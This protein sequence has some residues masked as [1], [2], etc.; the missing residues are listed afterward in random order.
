M[1]FQTSIS[2]PVVL[3]FFNRPELTAQVFAKIK[4]ARPP[5]LFLISDGPRSGTPVEVEKVAASRMVVA[6]IDWPCEVFRNYSDVNLGCRQRVI[7]GLDWVFSQVDRAIILEDDCLPNSDFFRF[8]DEL[9]ERY[10]QD[11]RVGSIAGT[12]PLEHFSNHAGESYSF[13][14]RPD[15]WGWATW[16]RVWKKYDGDI[17]DWPAQ[18]KTNLLVE[19]F[20]NRRA[21]RYWRLALSGVY[22][23]ILDTWDIQLTYH[24]LKT[25][26]VSVFPVK[27]LVANIGFGPDATHTLDAKNELA[28]LTTFRMD[29]PLIHPNSIEV[30][31][32]YDKERDSRYSPAL[33]KLWLSEITR[34]LPRPIYYFLGAVYNRLR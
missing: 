18:Q 14:R 7:S 9:L 21:I 33:W 13:S 4:E 26:Q 12:N 11:E 5:K 34:R 30:N 32:K 20:H 27:N 6:E 8:T 17:G 31:V 22:K 29:S 2:S 23:K 19:N 3:I 15:I 16:A 10:A 28:N 24:L 1:S 25:G